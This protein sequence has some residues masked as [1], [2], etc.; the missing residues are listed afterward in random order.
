MRDKAKIIDY[1]KFIEYV[2]AEELDSM[3]GTSPHISKDWGVRFY[4]SKI[5]GKACVYL[6]HSGTEFVF[7]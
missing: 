4:T 2:D 7:I 1:K 6:T 3:F 5:N